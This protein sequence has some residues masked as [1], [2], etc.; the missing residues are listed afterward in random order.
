MHRFAFV[1]IW[2]KG[3]VVWQE[4]EDKIPARYQQHDLDLGDPEDR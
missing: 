2:K 3:R 4:A 1:T